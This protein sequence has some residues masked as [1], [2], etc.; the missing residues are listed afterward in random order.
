MSCW[1]R[2]RSHGPFENELF[3][4]I[5]RGLANKAK[6]LVK[7]AVKFA[8]NPIKGVVDIAKSGL[9]N[10]R[11]RTEGHRKGLLGP[12]LQRL[13]K[14][15]IGLLEGRAKEACAAPDAPVACR[16]SPVRSGDHQG[17]RDRRDRGRVWRLR[18]RRAVRDR[19]SLPSSRERSTTRLRLSCS[20]P[21]PA[22]SARSSR[23]ASRL[24]RT[25]ENYEAS[26]VIRNARDP[27]SH[28]S[29]LQA[30]TRSPNSTTHGPVW[31]PNSARTQGPK[32]R[33]DPYRSSCRQCSRLGRC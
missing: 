5:V 15:G 20:R 17:P 19:D 14:A 2:S 26:E 3:G 32:A 7:R 12:L 11:R 16:R 1:N 8:K 25:V 22:S 30:K 29:P 4:K 31:P 18:G 6:S 23:R 10:D 9:G 24:S 28:S 27:S 21:R 13:K 33:L